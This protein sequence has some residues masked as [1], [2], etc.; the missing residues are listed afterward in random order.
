MR[1]QIQQACQNAHST[2][3]WIWPKLIPDQNGKWTF[4]EKEDAAFSVDGYLIL[5]CKAMPIIHD[6]FSSRNGVKVRSLVGNEPTNCLW[7]VQF[8]SKFHHAFLSITE[9]YELR[10][11]CNAAQLN[12]R[13]WNATWNNL[14]THMLKMRG[15]TNSHAKCYMFLN[16]QI[17]FLALNWK[18]SSCMLTLKPRN[19]AHPTNLI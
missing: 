14:I 5:V 4:H 15:L 6:V 9:H 2:C 18:P 7:E 11:Q 3:L 10:T 17:L 12:H 19:M 16:S 8:K 1:H 13:K